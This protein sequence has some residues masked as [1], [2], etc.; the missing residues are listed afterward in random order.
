[1]PIFSVEDEDEAKR[2]IIG[3]CTRGLL[4]GVYGIPGF[5]GELEDIPAAQQRLRDVYGRLK[6]K[7][8]G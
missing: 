3:A 7:G 2:L 1:L 8:D 5:A 4:P 6:K